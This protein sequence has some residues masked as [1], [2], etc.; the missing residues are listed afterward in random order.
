[1]HVTGGGGVIENES[2][3]PTDSFIVT[4]GESQVTKTL[5]AQFLSLLAKIKESEVSKHPLPSCKILLSPYYTLQYPACKKKRWGLEFLPELERP[6][7]LLS[8]IVYCPWVL[9]P[10]FAASRFKKK[11]KKKPKRK[12]RHVSLIPAIP[13]RALNENAVLLPFTNFRVIR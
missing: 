9:Y 2:F 7:K 12:G 10:H 4:R 6:A 1:V 5:Q 11:K 13:L 8:G 3:L